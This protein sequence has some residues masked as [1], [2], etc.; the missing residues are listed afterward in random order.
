MQITQSF[1]CLWE[2]LLESVLLLDTQ[3]TSCSFLPKFHNLFTIDVLIAP[4]EYLLFLPDSTFCGQKLCPFCVPLVPWELTVQLEDK[5]VKLVAK[6]MH[7]DH[8]LIN[9]GRRPPR[10]LMGPG[11]TGG[12]P[13][14]FQLVHKKFR[15]LNF[16]P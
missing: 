5:Q 3:I 4:L 11:D 13:L 2:I 16:F 9:A 14:K 7:P 12:F 10:I 1:H 15:H 6:W 8:S